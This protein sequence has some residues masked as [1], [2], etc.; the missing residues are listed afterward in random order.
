MIEESALTLRRVRHASNITDSLFL[1]TYTRLIK[2]KSLR[3]RDRR[4]LL[5]VAAVFM[6]SDDPALQTFG[7]RI[8]VQYAVVTGDRLP[9]H[10]VAQVKELMPLVHLLSRDWDSP[11][12]LGDTVFASY[13]AAIAEPRARGRVHRTKWQHLIREHAKS[14]ND[15]VIVAPTSYGKSE[16]IVERALQDLS[17]RTV[18]LVPTKALI[19]QT[20]QNLLRALVERGDRV[21]V[22]THP[23]SYNDDMSFIGVLTQERFFRLLQENRE[24]A[25]DLL[26]VDEAHHLLSKDGRD[27]HLAQVI[28]AA[29]HRNPSTSVSY[30]TPFVTEASNLQLISTER[31]VSGI[32]TKETVKV[33]RLYYTDLAAGELYLYD[34]F[35]NRE[36]RVGRTESDEVAF[37]RSKA[38]N[39]NVIYVNKPRDA[40][41]FAR[42]LASSSVRTQSPTIAVALAAI[43]ELIHPKYSL[44]SALEH[45]VMFHHGKVP[46]I[47]RQYVEDV[48]SRS[49][50]IKFL[51]T[52]ST[53]LEGV[54]TPAERMFIANP[55]KGPR[56]LT[57]SGFKNL[58]GRVARFS[59]IFAPG[60]QSL[61]LLQPHIY[62]LNGETA[63]SNFSPRSFL[64]RVADHARPFEDLVQN[65]L[66]EQSDA[67]PEARNRELEVLANVEPGSVVDT[68]GLRI[69]STEIGRLCFASNLDHFDILECE[70]QL[71]ENLEGLRSEGFE[72]RTAHEILEAIFR[73]FWDGI[74]VTRSDVDR[75][76]SFGEARSFYAMFLEWRMDGF[77]F[78]AIIRSF[79]RY[80]ATR[81]S[82]YVWVG[83][84]WG[85]VRIGDEI[86]A[87]Y[88]NI[89]EKTEAEQ[90][91]LA[92]AK[93]KEEQDF[94]DYTLIPYV[95]VLYG[96]GLLELDTYDRVMYGTT[97]KVLITLLKNGFSYELSRLLLDDYGSYLT[98]DVDNGTCEVAPGVVG[99]MAS[100]SE[101]EVLL[102]EV[103]CNVPQ[104][105]SAS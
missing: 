45:G 32:S 42:R 55:Y 36:L 102:F 103:Q 7:Y 78:R 69:A 61:D 38:L 64:E 37:V 63:S 50:E 47:I 65:P 6:Q 67:Q 91:T 75:V 48:Y 25:V 54:N 13:M 8:V 41:Y 77:P 19:A 88:V 26:L 92:V 21:K 5:E 68:T 99:A 62:V 70:S 9:L 22:L 94:L 14:A 58:I 57:R 82:S 3:K 98:V 2:G 15:S 12:T 43:A 97:D 39:K 33:E 66:L 80:W 51:V 96:L 83:R 100:N 29:Q 17:R 30:F 87:Q 46:E 90:V 56:H 76:K 85:E 34:Q 59:E 10:R 44:I 20:R 23:E 24:L 4:Y 93:A 105:Q 28:L 11:T 86:T 35:L 40:E 60:N 79:L 49:P 84:S 52:T 81:P 101:N 71:N 89:R 1:K 27:T 18:V 31:R 53:L 74:E 73:V 95:E 104:D 72:A 16:M